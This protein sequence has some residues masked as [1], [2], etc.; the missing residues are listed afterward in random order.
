[1]QLRVERLTT[2]QQEIIDQLVDIETEAFGA[3]GL[4]QWG[5][6]PFIHHGAVYI[7]YQ[8]DKPV[9]VIEYMRDLDQPKQAY[10]YGLAISE[11]YQGQGLGQK[12]LD[13]SLQQMQKLGITRVELTVDP[14]N[15]PAVKLYRKFGFQKIDFRQAEYG[16]AEDRLIIYLNL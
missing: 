3:G 12:L 6:V 9:G 4:N 11:E 8:A 14:A 13:Y 15:E 5:L 10:L 2:T 16:P 7:I 1:M